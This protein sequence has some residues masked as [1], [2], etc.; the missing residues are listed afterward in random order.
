MEISRANKKYLRRYLVCCPSQKFI[1]KKPNHLYGCPN[2]TWRKSDAQA[3]A[4]PHLAHGHTYLIC[5]LLFSPAFSLARSSLHRSLP[6]P[7]D[8][9][10][11]T[12][13]AAT[14]S[15][16]Y[17][18]KRKVSEQV[19]PAIGEATG[20]ATRRLSNNSGY[21]SRS[22]HAFDDPNYPIPD[23]E[24]VYN[25]MRDPTQGLKLADRRWTLSTYSKCFVGNEAVQWMVDNLAIDRP[26]AVS[27]GQRLMNAGIVQ[28]VT[29]SEPF[30]DEYYFYRFQEDDDTNILNMKRV[31]DS[32]IPTRPAVDVSKDLLTRL[33]LLC[34]EHRKRILAGK[35]PSTPTPSPQAA[36]TFTPSLPPVLPTPTTPCMTSAALGA[37]SPSLVRS[38]SAPPTTSQPPVGTSPLLMSTQ[39]LRRMPTSPSLAA[40]P[41]YTVG[42]DVDYTALAKSEDFRQYTLSAAELQRV[43]LVALN[44]EERLAFFVNCYNLLC[45]HGYVAHGPPNN[46]LRRYVFF[47]ALSYRIAGLDMTLDD[48][49]H[50]ILRGNKRP[51]MIKFVQQ[52]RPSDPKCLH[53]LSQRDGR[54]HFVISAGTR[55]DPPIRI[56]DGE[57]V[58]EELHTATVEFLTYSVK[59]DVEKRE[60]TLPRILKWYAEDFPTPEKNLLLWIV[61]YLPVEASHQLEVLV[62]GSE[63]PPTIL[64]ADFDWSNAEARFNAA[65]IRRKRRKLEKEKLGAEQGALAFP[66]QIQGDGMSPLFSGNPFQVESQLGNTI[67]GA[68]HISLSR[69]GVRG[70]AASIDA[71]F[72]TSDDIHQELQGVV[73]ESA[74][75]SNASKTNGTKEDE[76]QSKPVQPAENSSKNT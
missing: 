60:V 5:I 61:K 74:A 27:R 44:Q 24:R 56:L 51:P 18:R 4:S 52:L 7:P 12:A 39:S 25:T 33:A 32:A 43:Q 48:I 68:P 3:P 67:V 1:K 13:A 50:G 19:V 41:A 21:A 47:R 58:H 15:G 76:D 9:A 54:I 17:T 30:C 72:C 34:E 2:Q 57:N 49:E 11:A 22:G 64:H 8:P 63:T 16:S 10:D 36:S 66:F 6:H 28:H 38:L 23:F 37:I 14:M 59:V 53:V 40:V 55:S 62:S 65:V 29:Q 35:Q 45:L 73:S 70:A 75:I 46:W 20:A 26:T 69:E 71:L 42:D 31:W